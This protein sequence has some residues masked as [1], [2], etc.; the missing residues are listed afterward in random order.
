MGDEEQRGGSL[1]KEGEEENKGKRRGFDLRWRRRRKGGIRGQRRGLKDSDGDDWRTGNG[2]Q[3]T[4]TIWVFL[5]R[6]IVSVE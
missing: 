6:L 2:T 3:S 1:K 4:S 5:I